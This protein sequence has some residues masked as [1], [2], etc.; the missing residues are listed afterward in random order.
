MK[1]LLL[2]GSL[3]GLLAGC[4][5]SDIETVQN[6]A[7]NFNPNLKIAY[8]F[9]NYKGCAKNSVKWD[10]TKINGDKFVTF[11]CDDYTFTNAIVKMQR[12]APIDVDARVLDVKSTTLTFYFRMREDGFHISHVERLLKWKDGVTKALTVV[13]QKAIDKEMKTIYRNEMG[14]FAKAANTSSIF[15]LKNA[16]KGVS[17]SMIDLRESR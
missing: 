16:A 7:L 1:K 11:S 15:V 10:S 12:W 5:D 6:G 2:I 9:D 14:E 4:S 8:V 17:K 13:D 3:V